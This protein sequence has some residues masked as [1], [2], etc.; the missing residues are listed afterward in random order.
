MNKP[1]ALLFALLLSGCAATG[2][3]RDVEGVRPQIN[4]EVKAGAGDIFFNHNVVDKRPFA[5]PSR[6]DMTVKSVSDKEIVLEY[7]EYKTFTYS[8][9]DKVIMFKG[10][11]FEIIG[12]ENGKVT[13]RRIR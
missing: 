12:V 3:Q 5:K 7:G 11:Q 13:Y 8:A 4:K 10:Y 9:N 6:F 2:V 1:F